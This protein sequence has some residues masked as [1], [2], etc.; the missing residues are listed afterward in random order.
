MREVLRKNWCGNVKMIRIR[1]GQIINR[2]YQARDA[3]RIKQRFKELIVDIL[4]S[5]KVV[6][7]HP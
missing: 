2:Y 4:F 3:G 7:F 1:I 6:L 5:G